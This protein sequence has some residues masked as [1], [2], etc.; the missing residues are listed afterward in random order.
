MFHP[1]KKEIVGKKKWKLLIKAHTHIQNG[2]WKRVWIKEET[3]RIC[4][5]KAKAKRS[6]KTWDRIAQIHLQMHM[7]LLLILPPQYSDTP[8]SA[9]FPFLIRFVFL[10]P[11]FICCCWCSSNGIQSTEGRAMGTHYNGEKEI[12]FT[13]PNSRAQVHRNKLNRC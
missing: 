8:A 10:P 13:S 9:L 5:D 2:W 3:I 12:E 6:K 7:S 1:Y 4:C 11:F